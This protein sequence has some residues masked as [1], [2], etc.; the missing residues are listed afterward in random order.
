[1]KKEVTK[2]PQ[3]PQK[4]DK[5]IELENKIK[6]NIPGIY[7]IE[8]S[9]D[10]IHVYTENCFCN[11]NNLNKWLNIF[12]QYGIENIRISYRYDRTHGLIYTLQKKEQINL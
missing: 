12:K 1:M 10:G 8:H 9:G 4:S 7:K 3:Q 5:K 2:Q 11:T 6:E